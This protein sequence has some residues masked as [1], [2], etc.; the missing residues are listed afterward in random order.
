MF[1]WSYH[2]TYSVTIRSFSTTTLKDTETRYVGQR[3]GKKIKY[4]EKAGDFSISA[5]L[6]RQRQTTAEGVT[7]SSQW[8]HVGKVRGGKLVSESEG[9]VTVCLQ[10]NPSSWPVGG[11]LRILQRQSNN[12]WTRHGRWNT[13]VLCVFA[14]WLQ[15]ADEQVQDL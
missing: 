14:L 11:R 10:P 13:F 2:L 4:D 9:W 8:R 5:R 12:E 7:G 6:K 3:T 15:V 1:F